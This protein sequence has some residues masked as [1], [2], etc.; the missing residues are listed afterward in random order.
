MKKNWFY[1]RM[2]F[3]VAAVSGLVFVT[4]CLNLEPEVDRTRFYVLAATAQPERVDAESRSSAED[5]FGISMGIV[6]TAAYLQS[7][8]IV[9]RKNSQEI[10]YSGLMQWAE[11]LGDGLSRVVAENLSVWL[12]TSR[13]QIVRGIFPD[14]SDFLVSLNVFHFDLSTSG[15]ATVKATWRVRHRLRNLELSGEFETT[16]A[17][18]YDPLDFSP[19][20][21]ALSRAVGDMSREIARRLESALAPESGSKS[22][23]AS[24]GTQS[25]IPAG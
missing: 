25:G 10:R 18:V 6:G 7:S 5:G 3:A 23:A 24:D 15:T 4:G 21:D 13:V 19:G 11:P 12:N 1:H 14:D 20:V 17:F 9:V 2:G 8:S 16:E 22:S